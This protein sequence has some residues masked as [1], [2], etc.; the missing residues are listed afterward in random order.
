MYFAWL[1]LSRGES[2][3]SVD[4]ASVP[5]LSDPGIDGSRPSGLDRERIKY[6]DLVDIDAVDLT[7]DEYDEEDDTGDEDKIAS[8]LK[9]KMKLLWTFY[10]WLV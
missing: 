9:G 1:L 8:R 2:G 5:L 10:Y 7:R 3:Q 6:H 4:P